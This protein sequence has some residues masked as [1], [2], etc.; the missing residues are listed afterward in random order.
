M[1]L[2]ETETNRY[3][4]AGDPTFMETDKKELK[5]FIAFC[6]QMEL[7]EMPSLRDHRS[8]RPALGG[9]SFAGRIIFRRRFEQQLRSLHF[10]DNTALV[11]A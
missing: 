4:K 6:I 5:K 3:G 9:H 11:S 8:T 1:N 7:V 2:I 10:C